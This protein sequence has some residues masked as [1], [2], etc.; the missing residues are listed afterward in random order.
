MLKLFEGLK[1][2]DFPGP[3]SL[4]PF[5]G[6]MKVSHLFSVDLLGLGG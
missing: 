6:L 2:H 3:P 5:E 1:E 4:Q